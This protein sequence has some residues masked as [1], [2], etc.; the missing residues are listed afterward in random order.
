M[1][2]QDTRAHQPL[3]RLEAVLNRDRKTAT[4]VDHGIAFSLWRNNDLWNLFPAN[5]AVNQSK[6]DR[7]PTADLL[8]R[9]R[10]SIIGC[11]ELLSGAY[12]DR[13]KREAARAALPSS[14]QSLCFSRFA[15][16]VEATA[17]QRQVDRWEP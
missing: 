7:L 14:W 11:W 8:L 9:R 4:Y 10:D 16:A 6:S 2:R 1:E 15:E 13:F 12:P 5:S 3:E 17:I